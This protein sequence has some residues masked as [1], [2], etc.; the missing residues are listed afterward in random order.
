MYEPFYKLT[1]KP[2][3]LSPDPRF[4]YNSKGHKRAL[5]YLRYGIRQG[6]GFIVVTGDVGTG[7]STLV[8]DLFEALKRENVVAAQIV[9]TQIEGDDLLR[10]VSASFGLPYQDVTKGVLLRNLEVFFRAC[11]NERKR[12]LLVID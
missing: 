2:F 1:A 3:R 5:A 12:V 10:M 4:F 11:A 7:K 8:S 6:E 9:T